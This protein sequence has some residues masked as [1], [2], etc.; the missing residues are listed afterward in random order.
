MSWVAAA[1]GVGTLAY[2]IYQK[3]QGK[4]DAKKG[5][6]KLE[7]EASKKNKAAEERLE[8][9]VRGLPSREEYLEDQVPATRA[10]A[11][12]HEETGKEPGMGE[13]HTV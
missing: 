8:D 13:P 6:R 4:K 10:A 12:H 7:L 5:E 1:V 3:E 11:D 2:G 9:A